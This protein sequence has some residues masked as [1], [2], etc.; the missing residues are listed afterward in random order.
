VVLQ[1]C[2]NV[3]DGDHGVM[4]MQQLEFIAVG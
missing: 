3:G 1:L 4:I 2:Y